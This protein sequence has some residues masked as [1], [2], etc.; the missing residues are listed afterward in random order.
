MIEE[1]EKN[2]TK[3]NKNTQKQ[4]TKAKHERTELEQIIDN[5]K[6]LLLPRRVLN[7]RVK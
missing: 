6:L 7:G 5:K 2:A 1:R 3:Q 4:N